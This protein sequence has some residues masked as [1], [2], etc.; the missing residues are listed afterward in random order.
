MGIVQK[1][2]SKSSEHFCYAPFSQ[3]LLA[4]TGKIYPCCYHFGYELGNERQPL[5]E[6]WNGSAIRKLRREFLS[7]KPRI[8]RSRMHNTGCHRSF[9][10][11]ATSSEIREFQN[12]QPRRLDLRLGGQCNL[13]CV[14]CDVWQQPNGKYDHSIFWQDV[15]QDLLEH[16]IEVDIVGGEPF[17]QREVFRLIRDLAT[18]NPTVKL[19]AITNANYHHISKVLK[20]L[21]TVELKMLQVSLDA[22]S[23]ESYLRVRGSQN[24]ALVLGNARKYSAYCQSRASAKFRISFCVLQQNWRDLP[25]FLSLCRQLQ[26]EPEIQYA[27]YDPSGT[28]SLNHLPTDDLQMIRDYLLAS[29]PIADHDLLEGALQPIH[30]QIRKKL[31]DRK[32]SSP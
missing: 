12:Y 5:S 27:F 23:E 21:D 22:S 1:K 3:L 17:I 25:E 32:N 26:A 16:L 13:S 8:C 10:H 30:Q 2:T 20:H 6:V 31:R 24:F 15:R 18:S 11:L 9:D 14:M 4:P 29:V 28:S 19:S 7:G